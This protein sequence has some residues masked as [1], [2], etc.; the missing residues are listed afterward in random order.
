M[1]RTLRFCLFTL[2]WFALDC[3]SPAHAQLFTVTDLGALTSGGTSYSGSINNA[4]FVTGH[5]GINGVDHAIIWS[6]AT[7]QMTDLGTPGVDSSGYS[8]NMANLVAGNIYVT[9]IPDGFPRYETHA[10]LFGSGA[11]SGNPIE[12]KSFIDLGPS[13]I[14][15]FD[16]NLPIYNPNPIQNPSGYHQ[17]FSNTKGINDNGLVVGV[18]SS[19]YSV[20]ETHFIANPSYF[21]PVNVVWDGARKACYWKP[22]DYSHPQFLKSLLRDSSGNLLNPLRDTSASGT[23]GVN[24]SGMIVGNCAV[25]VS[26]SFS[27]TVPHACAWYVSNTTSDPIDIDAG[28]TRE[29]YA[30]CVSNTGKVAGY[31]FS[32][33]IP[34]ELLWNR[35]K[36]F[37]LVI[38][39]EASL[40]FLRTESAVWL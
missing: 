1:Y 12:L 38:I 30:T 26:N 2:L 32:S 36:L 14:I 11:S 5:S 40:E 10:C 29:S 22:G 18:S 17:N 35:F 21:G 39:A 7:R 15:N 13:A 20:I 9:V 27:S 31:Y 33:T 8:I 16:P 23:A 37:A 3:T 28:N 34:R 24:T 4:G 25:S 19:L 6:P